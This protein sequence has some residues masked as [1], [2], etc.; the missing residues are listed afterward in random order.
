MLYVTTRNDQEAFTVQHV[1]NGNRGD[2]GGLYLPLHFPKLSAN[3]FGV[4]IV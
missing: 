2:D 4:G 3:D 1:M